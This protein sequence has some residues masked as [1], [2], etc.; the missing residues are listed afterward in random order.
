[1]GVLCSTFFGLIF[2]YNAQCNDVALPFMDLQFTKK[3]FNT[4]LQVACIPILDIGTGFVC[5]RASFMT[6]GVVEITIISH[7]VSQISTSVLHRSTH[8]MPLLTLHVIT[9]MDRTSASVIMDS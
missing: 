8:A 4:V 5:L 9:P 6:R 1:M 7:S 2:P 3:P